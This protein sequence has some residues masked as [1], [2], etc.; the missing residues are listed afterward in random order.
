MKLYGVMMSA[1]PLLSAVAESDCPC[2]ARGP[3]CRRVGV[4][5]LTRGIELADFIPN[6]WLNRQ[7][8]PSLV[9]SNLI[10]KGKLLW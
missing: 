6:K 9:W 7:D 4:P 8:H 3:D 10:E 2:W 5:P 1:E